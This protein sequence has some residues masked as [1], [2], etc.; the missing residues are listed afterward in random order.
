MRCYS[1][2]SDDEKEQ[3]GLVKA[4]GHSI[5]AISLIE[6]D[7]ALRTFVVDRFAEGWSPEQISGWLRE[8]TNVVCGPWVA[9]RSTPSSVGQP[10]GPRVRVPRANLPVHA[11]V[12]I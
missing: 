8:E 9:R 4:L 1:D 2:L 6:R 3:I 11:L 7:R 10:K 12:P 5:G